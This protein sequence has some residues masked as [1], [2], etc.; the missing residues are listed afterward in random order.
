MKLQAF[1]TVE[2]LMFCMHTE[3]FI[4]LS[5]KFHQL[6]LN[7]VPLKNVKYEGMF[8]EAY[9]ESSRTYKMELFCKNN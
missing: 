6:S 5:V 3:D 8:T 9:L 7:Y 2:I 4:F 1:R